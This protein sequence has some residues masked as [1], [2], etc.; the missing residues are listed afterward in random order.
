MGKGN[1]GVGRDI[2][3]IERNL[4]FLKPGGRMAV[5]LPQG[6]FNNSSDK[7]IRDFIAERCRILSVVGLHGNT[8]KPHT[9][10]KTSVLFLQKWNDDPHVGSL[11]P[12]KEDY[13]IFFATMQKSGKDNSGD[14]IYVKRSDS[15]G[16]FLLDEHGHRIVD[17]DLFNHDGLTQDGIAEAFIE[18]AKKEG[19]SFFDLG[20]SVTPF[21]A[22]KYERLM[23]ELEAVEL[24]LNEVF[25]E[26]ISLRMDSEY[27]QKDYLKNLREIEA[28]PSGFITFNEAI[29]TITGGATPLGAD[30]P[31]DGV[32]FL[33]VQN[34]MQNYIDDSDLVYITQKDDLDLKRSKLKENDVLLTITGVSYGKSAVVTQEFIDCNIN[35]HSVK[36][37]LNKQNFL[38][39]FISTFLNSKLGKLQSDKNIVG[40]T[41]PALDYAAIK[42]FKLPLVSLSFQTTI[43]KLIDFSYLQRNESKKFYQEAEDLLLSELG[44]KDWQPTEKTVAVKSFAESFLSSGRLDAEYYQ[45]KYDQL[46][47]RLKE[48]IE[49]TPLGDLLTFN[50]RGRQPIYI[51]NED[52]YDLGLSVIN[53]KHVREGE[54]LITDNRYAY[55]SGQT[56]RKNDV[57]IN[58]TGKGTIG[59]SAPYLYSDE[60]IPDNHVTILRTN[61]LD[62]AYLSLYL[63]SIVGK[64][65]VEKYFKGSSGQIELY[66]DEINQ[67][68]I[69]NA[70]HSF[71]KQIRNKFDESQQK[72]NQSQQLLEIAKIAVEKAIE[73][74]ETTAT[75]WINQQ[76]Q[77]LNI[78]I[79]KL[80]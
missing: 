76:L 61:L 55:I 36:I 45:P 9:G 63:N 26:N 16:D 29:K 28:Y 48:K 49:L 14:K 75:D 5:V 42:N 6:R 80:E 1:K 20:S 40:V 4:D 23:G 70:P 78:D 3:F 50:Q 30:Y 41:R 54:V 25:K 24:S 32:R 33:R 77:I 60:A 34:I 74:D 13:N 64:L 53:S 39:N 57:L 43:S 68:L 10:T 47:E 37:T 65:E 69:W 71:Q 19:L 18:F 58:G 56:I 11:C 15:S 27:F 31:E 44:L 79:Q 22:V 38:P 35:Q 21:D 59:R 73:T 67:F 2:L 46:I 17:H 52:E 72:K 66:P 62:P 12:K 7:Y 51:E 8:F